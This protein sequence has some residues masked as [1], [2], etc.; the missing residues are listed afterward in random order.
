MNAFDIARGTRIEP[1]T[2]YTAFNVLGRRRVTRKGG[3]VVGHAR[4]GDY[5][6]VDWDDDDCS[7]SDTVHWANLKPE[8]GEPYAPHLHV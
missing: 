1:A 7:S 8:G 2:A 3:T 6:L 5:V 4:G